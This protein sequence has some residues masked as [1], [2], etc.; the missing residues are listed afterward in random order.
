MPISASQLR[1]NIYR[2]L[3]GILESGEPVEIERKGRT[4][5]IM[6]A[7]RPKKLLR[8]DRR[9][10]LLVDPEEIVEIDWSS[11]WRP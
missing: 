6:P 3:D 10:Y 9:D 1:Q 4:L 11:E 2:I 7:D 5:K 8:L